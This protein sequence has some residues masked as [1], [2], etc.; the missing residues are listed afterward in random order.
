MLN[1][2]R[3]SLRGLLR[4]PTFTLV[5]VI[6][7][8]L[9]IGANTAIFSIVNTVLLRALPFQNPERIVSVGKAADPEGLPGIAGYEYLAWS[10]NSKDFEQLAAYSSD[11]SNL[12]GQGQPERVSCGQ[13]TA[14]FFNTLGVPVLRGR[15]FVPDEDKP[16]SQ[17]VILSEAF[18]QRRFGRN[19]S[20]VGSTVI[21]DDKGYVVVGIMPRALRF[22][23]DYDI[24]VPLALDKA[25]ETHGDMVSLVEV[26]GRL[27]PQA[28]MDHA[29]AELT[30]LSQQ[31]SDQRTE[32]FPV[33]AFE[34][35]PLHQFLVTGVRRT[36]L[37]LWAAVGLVM[38]L[39]C[40]NVASLMLSRTAARQREIA[41]RAAVGARRWQLVRQLLVESVALGIAAGLLGILIAVW[42]KGAIASL[43]PEGFTSSIHDLHTAGM[44]WRVFAFTFLLSVITGIVFGLIPALSASKPNLVR[45]FRDSGNPRF[46][47]FGLRSI[48]GWLVVG[49]LALA[50]VLLLSAGLL[51]RS[52]NQRQAIDLGFA[53]DNVLTFRYG[54]PRSKYPTPALSNAFHQQILDRIKVLPGV[55][56]AGVINHT[57]LSGFG[58]IAFMGIEGQ[59]KPDPKKDKPVGVGAVSPD[60]FRTM[61]IPLISGRVTEESDRADAPKV[62]VVNQAFAHHYFGNDSAVGKRVGFGCK[63]DLCRTIVGVVGNIRQESLTDEVVPELYL[64]ITQMPMNGMTVMVRTTTDPLSLTNAI[65]SQVLAID[66]NQP[67]YDVRT[68]QNRVAEGLSVSRSLM[69]LFSAFAVLALVL[70]SVGTY[71]IVSYSVGQRTHEIGIRMALGAQRT[72]VLK[73]ILRSGV[74]L[75]TVGIALGLASAFA[76][77]RFLTSLLFGVTATDRST[78]LLVSLGLFVVALA[79][80][81]I[82]ARRATKV[83][84]LV[85]LRRE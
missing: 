35:M 50:M 64:P 77:T 62:G 29:K 83:D 70:A 16:G 58:L 7:L 31:A 78:F 59:R 37:L 56:S 60:Y 68:L 17:A 66:P 76:L 71:G 45:S 82:P 57:P 49:E 61:K 18:W 85:A 9:G 69:L 23:N 46:I 44:D 74:I 22:P 67:I 33:T 13:V 48:R 72:H 63:E 1:D 42:C 41:V 5:A 2:I 38:L 84:P 4:H 55:E 10:E 53:A 54:L 80:S 25:R 75:A 30:L 28:S 26:V 24:W 73:L 3:Y 12:T 81:L 43:V 21:L 51:V 15:A 36:V 52:F 32:K 47:G 27:K 11:N 8:A 20:I 14:S 65:R 34:V 19:E 6:T 79:A 40:A 39:A